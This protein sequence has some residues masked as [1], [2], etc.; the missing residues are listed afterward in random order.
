MLPNI[1]NLRGSILCH[2]KLGSYLKYL[3]D[4]TSNVQ[5]LSLTVGCIGIYCI[6]CCLMWV[7]TSEAENLFSVPNNFN[8]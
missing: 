8:I 3:L 2:R 4:S 5:F 1:G 7:T 6:V